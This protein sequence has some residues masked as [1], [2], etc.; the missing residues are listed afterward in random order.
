MNPGRSVSGVTNLLVPA[1]YT[2]YTTLSVESA[3]SNTLLLR[4]MN[5]IVTSYASLCI[6]DVMFSVS[7]L[8]RRSAQMHS[9][10]CLVTQMFFGNLSLVSLQRSGGGRN[11]VL[12]ASGMFVRYVR[13]FWS[14][15]KKIFLYQRFPFRTQNVLSYCIDISS[16]VC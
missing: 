1:R 3:R 4:L 11:C 10:S 8:R 16:Y 2:C 13:V 7:Y 6:Y 9:N 14:L 15:G 12:F 5:S